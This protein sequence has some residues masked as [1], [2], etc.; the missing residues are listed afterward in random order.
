M[1][2][3]SNRSEP[4]RFGF[5]SLLKLEKQKNKICRTPMSIESKPSTSKCPKSYGPRMSVESLSLMMDF[6]LRQS[7]QSTVYCHDC[8]TPKIQTIRKMLFISKNGLSAARYLFNLMNAEIYAPIEAHPYARKRLPGS[9]CFYRSTANPIVRICVDYKFLNLFWRLEF[10]R[11]PIQRLHVEMYVTQARINELTNMFEG[12]IR[13]L[14]WRNGDLERALAIIT[15]CAET[16]R[17]LECDI[18]LLQS[19]RFPQLRLNAFKS[20]KVK[21]DFH[22]IALLFQ[23]NVTHI[24]LSELTAADGISFT[25]TFFRSSLPIPPQNDLVSA[26]LRLNVCQASELMT[27]VTAIRQFS[28]NLRRVE[29]LRHISGIEFDSDVAQFLFLEIE[30]IHSAVRSARIENVDLLIR[31]VYSL[32]PEEFHF[33]SNATLSVVCS[34]DR[35]EL[36]WRPPSSVSNSFGRRCESID[37]S[38]STTALRN[39]VHQFVSKMES[40]Y[41]KV[42]CY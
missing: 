25:Q 15:S 14:I 27:T 1:H 40:D 19:A 13:E 38:D 34:V 33:R 4:K 11:L 2:L 39:F 23:Q 9:L 6:W 3:F 10:I 18:N 37:L 24:D 17:H 12:S 26:R 35:V 31:C 36:N 41:G 22:Q 5:G 42:E 30:Q 20:L 16:L 28:P 21:A 29:F 7:D 8:T 32:Q